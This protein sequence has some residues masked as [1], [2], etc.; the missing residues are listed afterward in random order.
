MYTSKNN[1]IPVLFSLP[2]EVL[3]HGLLLGYFTDLALW[4]LFVERDSSWHAMKVTSNWTCLALHQSSSLLLSVLINRTWYWWCAIEC[5]V[6]TLSFV[7]KR[8][9]AID[10]SLQRTVNYSTGVCQIDILEYASEHVF[11]LCINLLPSWVCR[12]LDFLVELKHLCASRTTTCACG[13]I[14]WHFTS[15]RKVQILG[16]AASTSY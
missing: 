13:S 2:F 11:S 16:I 9:Q 10:S 8:P 7:S 5:I 3:C 15:W 14:T 1:F 6:L 4:D 12:S